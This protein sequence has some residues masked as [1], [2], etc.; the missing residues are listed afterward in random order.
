MTISIAATRGNRIYRLE[1]A[2]SGIQVPLH[3][4]KTKIDFAKKDWMI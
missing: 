2:G 4:F 3:Y 1:M